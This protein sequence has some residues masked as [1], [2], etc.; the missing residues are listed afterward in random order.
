MVWE[1]HAMETRFAPRS[2]LTMVAPGDRGPS[3]P[4]AAIAVSTPRPNSPSA[5][6][7]VAAFHARE[8]FDGSPS[9]VGRRVPAPPLPFAAPGYPELDG[10]APSEGRRARSHGSLNEVLELTGIQH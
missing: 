10:A 1:S 9:L 6:P 4:P 3:A 5:R 7:T 8:A 2:P